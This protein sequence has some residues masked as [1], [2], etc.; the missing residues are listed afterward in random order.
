MCF[1]FLV[2][3]YVF[4]CECVLCV[5]IAKERSLHLW[6]ELACGALLSEVQCLS[7]TDERCVSSEDWAISMWLRSQVNP[8]WF[9]PP[10]AYSSTG[11]QE[12]GGLPYQLPHRT[13]AVFKKE[14]NI[15]HLH[16]CTDVK[17]GK[18]KK[19]KHHLI[20]IKLVERPLLLNKHQWAIWSLI[21]LKH[22]H[23]LASFF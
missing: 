19:I 12:R 5:I 10:S 2:C 22:A 20:P 15:S 23:I 8:Y 13:N 3:A 4:E 11:R 14:K 7:E 1:S 21:Q 9:T 6:N 18:D 16:L 17:W